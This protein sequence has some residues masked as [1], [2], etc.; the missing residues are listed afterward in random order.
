VFDVVEVVATTL[1][2][3]CCMVLQSRG[4]VA[5]SVKHLSAQ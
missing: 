5:E 1:E 2:Y 4:D 3:E